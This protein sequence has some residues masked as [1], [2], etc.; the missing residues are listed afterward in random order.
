MTSLAAAAPLKPQHIA[1]IMDGNGRW[2]QQR[3]S[4]RSKGHRAGVKTT[5]AI[6]EA[7]AEQGV[8]YLTLFAFSS[9]NWQRPKSEV[10]LL[11]ELFWAALQ[12]E[13]ADLH[14]NQVRLRF[15]GDL[16]QFEARLK[17]EINKAE[18]LTA[19][20]NGL[21]LFIA[22][23]YGGRADIV[24]AAK[25]LAQQVSNGQLAIQDI[26]ETNFAQALSL[27]GIPD[28]D[29]FIRTGGEY[30]MSNFL[31]WQLAYAELYFSDCLWPDFSAAELAK[32]I[33]WY[34]E[35]QRRFGRT[36]EQIQSKT[37]LAS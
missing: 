19:D 35:R 28:P 17:A 10:S 16:T 14:K 5:R 15:I 4:A 1:I 30:R 13:V 22:V 21:Q 23:G 33:Q 24:N 12:R 26:G 29:L 3:G 27:T 20:N 6:V 8:E 7:A 18:E 31:L 34:G 37:P 2:A 32:A 9:E 36:G 25:Q 11:M